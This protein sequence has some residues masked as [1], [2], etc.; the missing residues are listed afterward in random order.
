MS[1]QYCIRKGNVLVRLKYL[2]CLQLSVC[3]ICFP[4]AADWPQASGPH[5]NFVVAGEAAT[6]F[7]LALNENIR[8]VTPLPS[9]GQGG[10]IVV[11]DRVFVTSHEPVTADTELGSD[12]VGLCFDAKTGN[13]LWRRTIPGVRETDLSSLFSDNTA[14]SPVANQKHVVF[15]NVGGSVQGFD[16]DGDLQWSQRWTPFGRHHARQHEPFLLNYSVVIS[17]VNLDDLPLEVTTKS[18]AKKLGRGVK[19]WNRLQK[20]DLA[21][22]DLQWISAAGTSVHSTSMSG[23]FADG[24]NGILTGRGGGHQPPEEPFGLSMLKGSDG[25]VL[26]ERSVKGYAAHQNAVWNSEFVVAFVQDQHLTLDTQTGETI[27]QVSLSD[28]I[29]LTKQVDGRYE[30]LHE[31]K[32][33]AVRKPLT[34]QTN[35][36]VGDY[37]YFRAHHE[38]LL[39]RVHVPSGKVEYLQVPVQVKRASGEN[40]LISWDNA[41]QNDMKNANGFCV[42][43]DRRN[44]G[45]G[46][47]HVSA[48]SPI[49]VGEYLYMPTM[50]GMVYVVR[51][52]AP[53]LDENALVAVADLGPLGETWTLSSLSYSAGNLYARTLKHLICI[54]IDPQEKVDPSSE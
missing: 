4:A 27:N 53:R 24:T 15:V 11:G 54:G 7:S 3:W 48:A 2:L 43:Q 42:T 16:H 8:W 50:L 46:W 17:R 51:W 1:G 19:Y 34:Y 9:T 41:V 52:Q 44:A 20:R 26:W 21:T 33:K 6:D 12:I 29:A 10:V 25:S 5:G 22:G 23:R 45:D 31:A 37:H 13:E 32:L 28:N 38:Y 39:G 35:L 49:V 47:G 36:L 14:A 40:D 30:T 18:G